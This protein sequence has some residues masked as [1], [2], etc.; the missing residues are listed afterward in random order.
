[1]A[2]ISMSSMAEAIRAI[3]EPWRRRAGAKAAFVVGARR[4]AKSKAKQASLDVSAAFVKWRELAGMAGGAKSSGLNGIEHGAEASACLAL[5]IACM[6]P[7]W[8]RL[9]GGR[10]ARAAEWRWRNAEMARWQSARAK[11][12]LP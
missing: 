11:C 10:A 1:M 12:L 9:A 8:A 7:A 5:V 4:L 3:G 2:V 6:K